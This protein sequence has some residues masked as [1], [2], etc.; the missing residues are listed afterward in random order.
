MAISSCSPSAHPSVI[1][2]VRCD[3][4]M[5]VLVAANLS[6]AGASLQ[7][8]LSR[9]EGERTRE[10]MWGCEYPAASADW[11]VY[12]PAHGFNWWLL[13]EVEEQN[14]ALQES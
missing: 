2:Y 3:G 1:S 6:A 4:R 14:D 13:G 11:F 8:D 5:T 12:L 10:V 9:W 7:L